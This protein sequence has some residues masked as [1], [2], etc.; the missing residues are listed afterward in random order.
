MYASHSAGGF[1]QLI[2]LKLTRG[3]RDGHEYPCFIGKK[4]GPHFDR[5]HTASPDENVNESFCVSVPLTL[6]AWLRVSSKDRRRATSGE[7]SHPLQ[8]PVGAVQSQCPQ[9]LALEEK[10]VGSLRDEI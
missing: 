10:G 7:I 8:T 4:T 2:Y 3:Q 1:S 6:P 9:V 5:G